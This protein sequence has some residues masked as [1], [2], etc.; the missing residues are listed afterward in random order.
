MTDD[1]RYTPIYQRMCKARKENIERVFADAKETHGM[2]YTKYTSLAQVTNWGEAYFCCHESEKVCKL[3]VE[4]Y[5]FQLCFP[6][7]FN[8]FST[9]CI[10]PLSC[11]MQNRGFSTVCEQQKHKLVFLLFLYVDPAVK[12]GPF[13]CF[14]L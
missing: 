2:R 11:L 6:C 8:D 5:P 1:A 13:F 10:P 9:I 14:G 4:R 7:Y 3:A 12:P